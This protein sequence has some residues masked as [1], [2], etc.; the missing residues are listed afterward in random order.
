M[1][2]R[3]T[4]MPISD[5]ELS[6][7]PREALG[8]RSRRRLSGLLIAAVML[9]A[10]AT[11]G[12][13]WVSRDSSGPP[14]GHQYSNLATSM[15]SSVW[16]WPTVATDP[17][18]LKEAGYTLLVDRSAGVLSVQS[19]QGRYTMPLTAL[20]GRTGLPAGTRFT[21]TTDRSILT[22]YTFDRAG[23]LLEKAVLTGY[24]SFFTVSFCSQLGPDH[25]VGATFFSNG[26]A[27]L[28]TTWLDRAFSP[29]PVPATI[30]PT[31]TTF[32][33]VH[34]PYHTAP[35][36]P[37]PFDLLFHA[38]SG[39]TGIGL[40]QIPDATSLSLTEQGAIAVNYPL[41]ELATIQDVGSGGSI[42]QP[43]GIPGGPASGKWL[44]FPSLVVT[45]GNTTAAGLLA[46]HTSLT[47]LGEAPV[48]A[49][50]GKRPSWWSWPMVDTWGQQ[51]VSG[52]DRTSPLYTSSWVTSFVNSWR[53]RFG[54]THFTVII[55]AQWQARLGY[56]T[57]SARFGGVTGMR[58]LIQKLHSEGLKVI[59]W[60]PLWKHQSASG[61]HTLADPT[62]PGFQVQ[63]A[64]QMADLLGSGPGQLDANGLKLDWGFL[65][66]TPTQEHLARP[67]LGIG[68]ALLLRYMTVLS[69]SAWSTQPGALIDGS[70]VAPQFGGTE[71]TLRLYDAAMASTWSYRASIVT[72][73]DPT[74]LIDGD[75]W[76]LNQAQA[77]THT[78]QSAVFG[79]PALYYATKWAGGTPIT[80]S[81]ARALGAVLSLGQARG[82]GLASLL[83]SG[84]WTYH[85]GGRLTATTL[86]SSQALAV[87]G[88][89]H[90]ETLT[91]VTVVSALTTRVAVPTVGSAVAVG[92]Q[93]P[94]GRRVAFQRR[95]S[96]VIFTATGGE[97]YQVTFDPAPRH[98]AGDRALPPKPG[99]AARR[100]SGSGQP[101]QTRHHRRAAPPR[102]PQ[103]SPSRNP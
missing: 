55:D 84:Q 67:Q 46:Y 65:V 68:A 28:P 42:A 20:V 39:W 14:L 25:F 103:P 52:A 94:G 5:R 102:E 79:V 26:R 17:L 87:Y 83:A 80:E 58:A 62:A 49:P 31:P 22:L 59:L 27:A 9:A 36:A 77:V 51:L 99:E 98:R 53:Q 74:S 93:G 29:D 95:G 12:E 97:R 21:A 23:G 66:P 76:H 69:H 56:P 3:V 4:A 44:A 78:V 90:S 73:V 75:G 48:A 72:A 40:V 86:A 11:G 71:D 88:Y 24:P 64:T 96:G 41:S 91:G 1:S 35:F 16:T 54:I 19:P 82:Q 60:W 30:E 8:Q 92:V 70:A 50:P 10:V 57:P 100:R 101:P 61:V 37:A 85:V 6:S 63:T 89:S 47:Q 43:K 2:R 45:F 32:L 33:G 18:A 81:L 15:L 38:G 13:V 34:H 7:P